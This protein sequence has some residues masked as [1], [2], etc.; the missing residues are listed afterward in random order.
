MN[1]GNTV[2]ELENLR[3]I[4]EN[5]RE[6]NK[7]EKLRE[8]WEAGYYACLGANGGDRNVHLVNELYHSYVECVIRE[9]MSKLG[10]DDQYSG[11]KYS[12][13]NLDDGMDGDFSI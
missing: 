9:E 12:D 8:T 10:L 3:K 6:M 4:V 7:P 13:L 1:K 2:I 11:L 5:Y